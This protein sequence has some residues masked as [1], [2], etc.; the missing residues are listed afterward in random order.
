MS[1]HRPRLRG[2]NNGLKLGS[3]E[4]IYGVGHRHTG[5]DASTTG[6]GNDAKLP[7]EG[8]ASRLKFCLELALQHSS[9]NKQQRHVLVQ[10]FEMTRCSRTYRVPASL[11]HISVLAKPDFNRMILS[12]LTLFSLAIG[13]AEAT[14]PRAITKAGMG[15]MVKG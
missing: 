3:V 5:G 8:H 2:V 11:T 10:G 14:E 6:R 9:S 13:P 1:R 4:L 15:R 12:E 7:T